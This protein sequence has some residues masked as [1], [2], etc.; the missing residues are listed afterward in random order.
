MQNAT[1]NILTPF[2]GTP[3]HKRLEAEGRILTRD[4]SKYN[5]RADVVFRPRHMS[6]EALLAGYQYANRRFYSCRS[7]C[8][9]LSRSRVRLY[10]TLPLNLAYAFALRYRAIAS[11]ADDRLAHSRAGVARGG[12]AAGHLLGA[13]GPRRRGHLRRGCRLRAHLRPAAPADRTAHLRM[14]R[15]SLLVYCLAYGRR[16]TADCLSVEKREGT[17]GLLFLTDLKGHD[18]VLGKLVA[19]SVRGFYGLLAVFPVL[20]IPLL[21]GG[22]TSGE[23]W[24][25]ALVLMDTFLFSLAIG[26]LGSALSRDQQRAMGANI[27]LLIFFMAAPAACMYALDYFAPGL[28]KLS[29]LLFSCPA[30]AFFLCDDAHYG[31]ASDHFWWSVG[32][33]H[34]LTWLLVLTAGWIVPRTWQDQPSRAEKSR[35]RESWHAWRHGPVAEQS[36]FRRRTLDANAFFWLAARARTSPSMSGPSSH[37]WRRGGWCAG[38]SPETSGW[39]RRLLS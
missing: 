9:R 38:R 12:A 22:I 27:T 10:W 30:Y 37:A 11:Q 5:G 23:F 8:R 34:G 16:S 7:I 20:A 17:L 18:V 29:P 14:A 25:V 6:P 33:I 24:R 31:M 2:P 13:P 39:T 3:L 19:T 15:R 28:G 32:V 36:A 21:L 4:W 35:W 26:I 1:F